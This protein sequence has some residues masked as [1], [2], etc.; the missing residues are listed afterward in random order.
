MSRKQRLLQPTVS[1]SIVIADLIRNQSDCAVFPR[2]CG[3]DPQ[4]HFWE[5]LNRVEKEEKG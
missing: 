2:H 3:L 4:S 1:P 5:I